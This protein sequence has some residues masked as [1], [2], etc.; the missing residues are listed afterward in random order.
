MKNKLA[1]FAVAAVI[2]GVAVAV[3]SCAARV[4]P[5]ITLSYI[6]ENYF[7]SEDFYDNSSEL[8]DVAGDVNG[9]GKS[10]VEIVTIS[11]G[12][13]LTSGQEQNNLT[14]LTMSMGGGQSRVYIMDKAYCLRY[15]DDEIL[16]D[17]S[18]Y[19][20]GCADVLV[21]ESGKVY[22]VGVEGNPL[23]KKL[24]LDDTTDVY[25]AL[26]FVTEMDGINFKNIDEIDA[27]AREIY[28]YI[29]KNNIN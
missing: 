3:Y 13:N 22:A 16:A 11:F 6:G 23:L 24:G 10:N 5:D 1:I 17:V 9:D 25:I 8:N 2:I 14:R 12:S 27:A 21:N 18:D 19:A 7:S 26:R 4:E 28:Q 29:I 15:A 20:E